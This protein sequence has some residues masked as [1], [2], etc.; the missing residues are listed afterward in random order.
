MSH[1][2]KGVQCYNCLFSFEKNQ[3]WSLLF[4]QSN[5]CMYSNGIQNECGL[6]KLSRVIKLKFIDLFSGIYSVDL[7]NESL[8]EWNIRL[9]K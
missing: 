7:V 9:K 4:I 2:F 6:E 5:T 1:V 8:Y 3:L